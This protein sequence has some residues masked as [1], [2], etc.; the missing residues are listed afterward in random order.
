MDVIAP[1]VG[2]IAYIDT[3]PLPEPSQLSISATYTNLPVGST[4]I[5][6]GNT[7][8]TP[9]E[10]VVKVELVEIPPPGEGLKTVTVGVPFAAMSPAGT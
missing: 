7:P 9:P 3:P 4:A 6:C 8:D 10:A 5:D 1:V 2:L